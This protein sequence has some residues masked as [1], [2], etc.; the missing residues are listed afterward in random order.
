MYNN[1]SWEIHRI[2]LFNYSPYTTVTPLIFSYE[3]F[4][5]IY[6]YF[7]YYLLRYTLS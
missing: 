6:L 1:I 5:L 4:V 7:V 2:L 3:L